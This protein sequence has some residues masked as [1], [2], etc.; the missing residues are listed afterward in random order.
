MWTATIESKKLD[1]GTLYVGVIFSNGQDSFTIVYPISANSLDSLKF[2][3]RS[4]L[5]DLTSLD[6]DFANL[7]LG[8][9]PDP[10]PIVVD[11]AKQKFITDYNKWLRVKK[12]I[13]VG[14]LT[15]NEPAVVNLLNLVKSEFLPAYLDI[16]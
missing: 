14:L 7:A 4:K 8:P 9:A 12:A 11:P 6:S 1:K 15:G 3:V 2:Q 10:T 5:D 13:D 16:L